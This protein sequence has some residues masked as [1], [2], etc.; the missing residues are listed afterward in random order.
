M[1]NKYQK[2]FI[3]YI[4]ETQLNCC[5]ACSLDKVLYDDFYCFSEE[6]MKCEH[7]Y[8]TLYETNPDCDLESLFEIE[9]QQK[10][11][12]YSQEIK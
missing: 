10:L 5:L 9:R 8:K 3:K 11:I 1:M 4:N 12:K 6:C 2:N 7:R